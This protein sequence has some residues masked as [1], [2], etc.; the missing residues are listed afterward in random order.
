MESN[1]IILY[2]GPSL[3]DGKPIVAIATGIS[4][5]SANTKTGK[6][7]QTWIIR[8]DIAPHI[9]QKTG[10]DI[11]VCGSCIQRPA[12]K[13]LREKLFGKRRPCYVKT[14]Q[15]P[16]SVFNAYHRKRWIDGEYP[17]IDTLTDDERDDL[18]DSVGLSMFRIGSYGDPLA[19]PLAVWNFTLRVFGYPQSTGYTHAWRRP[20]AAAYKNIVM[21]SCDRESDIRKA[22]KLGFRTAVIGEKSTCPAQIAPDKHT[23][24]TCLKCDGTTGD[25]VFS[26][27]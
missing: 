13:T 4:K 1:G 25:V 15:A 7:I 16:L 19:V 9:A 21:A 10:D 14:F 5:S 17:H 26:N 6:M 18:V 23:C 8:S 20:G 12:L 2:E 24:S 22:H 27:H 11:S 3:I